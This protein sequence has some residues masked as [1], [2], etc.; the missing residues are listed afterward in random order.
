[1]KTA[2]R[3]RDMHLLVGASGRNV[4]L[5]FASGLLQLLVA[6]AGN[7]IGTP[8]KTDDHRTEP[9]GNVAQFLAQVHLP[10]DPPDGDDIN[11]LPLD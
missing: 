4:R 3:T 9:L 8:R 5:P 6:A 10:V 2:H 7:G 1:M 11:P